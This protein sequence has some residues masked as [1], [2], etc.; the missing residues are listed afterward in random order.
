MANELIVISILLAILVILI[1]RYTEAMPRLI[2][3]II[4]KDITSEDYAA[5]TPVD[6][7]LTAELVEIPMKKPLNA[8]FFPSEATTSTASILMVPNWFRKEDYESSIKTAGIL[9]TVGYNVLLPIYHMS[10]DENF[11]FIFKKRSVG[12][13]KCQK[14]IASAYNYFVTR[15]EVDKRKIGVWSNSSGTILACELIKDFPIKAV[16]LENG[17]V[18]L[19][20][21]I[22]HMLHEKRNFPFLLTKVVLVLLLFPFLWK[23]RWL[24]KGAAKNLRA[25]PSFLIALREDPQKNLWETYSMLHKP[26]QLWFE[27]AL[28]TRA[29]RETWL[30]EYFLQIRSFYDL[31]LHKSPQPEFHHDF[32]IKR[33][34]KGKWPIEIR[35]STMPPQLDKIPLQIILSDNSRLSELR[36]WFSGASVTINHSLNYK[37]NDISV[38]QLMNVEPGEHPRQPWIKRDARKA[39]FSTIEKVVQCPPGKLNELM[40]RYFF[41]KSIF[42]SEEELKEEAKEILQTAIT[43]KHWKTLAR[44]DSETRIII[45]DDFEEPHISTTDNILLRG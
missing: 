21:D 34:K 35:I 9:N 12:P 2:F 19:W 29:I 36:I 27:H 17:P 38:I 7:G 23:T 1:T 25:C 8:W 15:P 24:S 30:Q 44:R 18:T 6:R 37:P 43:S 10:L 45:Q 11:E 40:E 13:K 5:M 26:R 31:W 28:N 32:S 4:A 42:L 14:M 39:L 20:N 33:K 16:V 3:W 41:L 22:A